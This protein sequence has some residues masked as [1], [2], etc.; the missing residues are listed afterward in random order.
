MQKFLSFKDTSLSQALGFDK[1]F[2]GY[3]KQSSNEWPIE[4]KD[5]SAWLPL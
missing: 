4:C 5:P 2:Y 1:S 3:A